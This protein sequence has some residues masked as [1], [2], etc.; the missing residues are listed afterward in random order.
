[1]GSSLRNFT[2]KKRK[3]KETSSPLVVYARKREVECLSLFH[4]E[5]SRKE[6]RRLQRK[7]RNRAD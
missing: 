4:L 7:S 1:V 2:E 3:R 6:G 5:G